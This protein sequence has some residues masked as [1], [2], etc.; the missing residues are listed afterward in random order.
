MLPRTLLALT[1]AIVVVSLPSPSG[2]LPETGSLLDELG[3]TAQEVAD[4]EAGKFV[5]IAIKPSSE[6]ELT[7]GVAFHVGVTPD[8]L[9]KELRQGLFVSVD[10]NTIST[11]ILATPAE[12]GGFAKLELK[13]D[14]A[15]QAKGY[16]EAKPGDALNLSA[17]EI[18]AFRRLG[19]GA[20]VAA[21]E[22]A[23]RTL[24]A[25]RVEAYRTKGL[26]GIAPYARK[27]GS[28]SPAEELRKA[29]E[30]S[31]GLKKYVPT[32]Y[33]TLLAYPESKPPG[34][35]EMFRWTYLNA[36]DVPTITLTHGLVFA[37]GDARVVVQRQFYASTGYNAEQ[38]VVAL[39][40]VEKGTVVVYANR[41]STDQVTGFGGSAKRSLGSK[42]LASQL[43]SLFEKARAKV[44]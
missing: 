34:T 10:P 39:L 42:I 16:L 7:A 9:V 38:A 12:A 14:P 2:A 33:Q 23:L 37:D 36:H 29:S 28:R 18:E 24:L 21:V 26:A 44:K 3:F 31:A 32:L 6:R 8:V 41:T 1:A 20:E 17:E 40:P 22:S 43:R 13:G 27:D 15:K 4:V 5:D 35:E 11:G 30:A 25:A 19:V